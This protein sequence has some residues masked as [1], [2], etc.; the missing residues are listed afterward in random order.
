ME[1]GVVAVADGVPSGSGGERRP[2]VE[3]SAV[4][5]SVTQILE[6][7]D[8]VAGAGFLVAG[9]TVVTCAHVVRAAGQEPGGRVWLAFPHLAGAPT[10]AGRVL[11][12]GWRAPEAEDVA[13]VRLE[14]SPPGA[15]E[16]ALGSAE[17]CR[18]HRV[19]AFG[20]PAQ[21]PPSGHFGY[22]VAGDL[23]PTGG[24]AGPLLQLTGANDLTTGF[25][26][27][28]VVDEVTGLVIGMV[29]AISG[30]DSHLKG[31]GIA[32]ATPTQALR[33]I[34]PELLEQQ[35]SPYRGLEPFTAE[36]SRWFHGREAAVER[37]LAG[38]DRQQRA[39]LL[40][41]PS[42]AGKSSLVQAGVLPALAEG[43]VPGSGQWLTLVVRP[44]E[45]LLA[46]LERAGLPG[47]TTEGII[48]AVERRLAADPVCRRVI[49]VIDQ[50][51]ELLAQATSG[52][53]PAEA[54]LSAAEQLLAAIGSQ[55]AATVIMVVRDD[56]YP[57]LAALA[58]ELLEAAAPGLLNVP[59]NLSVPELHAIITRPAHTAGARIEDGLAERIITDVLAADSTGFSP[60]Q[61]AG[62]LL[63][64][65]ELTLSQ[66]WERREDGRLTHRAYQQLGEVTGSLTAW[67][68]TAMGRLTADQRRVAQRILTALVR[69]A[70]D[71]HL[72]PA[73]RQQVPLDRLRALASDQADG[74]AFDEV[75]TALTRRRIVTTR[76]ASRADAT[77]GLPVAELIH[78]ALIRDWQDLR[79][80]VAEDHQFHAWLHRTGE[81]RARFTDSG[82][83]GDLL[84]GTDLAE[85]LA[86][87]RQRG[88]PS[89]IA[90]FLTVS[91]RRQQAA[92]RRTRRVNTVLACLLAMALIA[93]GGALW[94]RQ[95]AV[96]AQQEAVASKEVAQSR[97]LA[98]Q[99]GALLEADPELASL[100]AVQAYRT[101]PTDEAAASLFK[102]AALPLR[103]TLPGHPDSVHSVELSPNGRTLAT[104]SD[105]MARLWDTETGKR[106]KTITGHTGRVLEVT[107]SLDGRTLATGSDDGT[108]QLLDATTG[109]GRKTLTVPGG[110]VW[111]V[112]F[113]PDGRLATGSKDGTVR[114]WDVATGKARKPLTGHSGGVY[115]MA[116]SPDGRTLATGSDDKTVRLW[117]VATGSPRKALTDPS[118]SVHS[119]M[120]SPE[121][122]TLI[123]SG[124]NGKVLL[125]DVATGKTRKTLTDPS[126]EVNSVA[127][128][129]DGRTLATTGTDAKI[130][131]W[132][133][134]TGATRETLT[135]PSGGVWSVAFGPDGRTLATGSD[136]GTV[137]L[138][139]IATDAPRTTLTGSTESVRSVAFAPDGRTLAA[140]TGRRAR[141]W[142]AVRGD[143]RKPAFTS[144]TGRVYSVAFSPNGRTLA[145][146]TDGVVQ[147][148]DA[149]TGTSQKSLGS[150]AGSLHSMAFSPD[151]RTLVTGDDGRRVRLWDVATGDTRRT[152]TD[153]GLGVA[154]AA[155]SRDGRTLA[156]GS[157]TVVRLWDPVTGKLRRT[158]PGH[159]G[160]VLQVVFSPD[161]HTLATVDGWTIRL[162]DATTGE[163]RGT[164]TGH[165]G[166]V[167]SVAFSPDG[168]T[169]ATTGED[170]KVRLWDVATGEI[171]D[172]F[173]DP[174]GIAWSV[175]FSPDGRTLATG[176]D[177]GAV[178][179]WDVTL[180]GPA[181]A[182]RKIC[183]LVH[184][185]FSA[186]ERSSYL[187]D[188]KPTPVCPS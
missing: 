162:W 28:P 149:A 101:R 22:G 12:E 113:A 7:D 87:S 50:F 181:E 110:G 74:R 56:F 52:E 136:N 163:R 170:V 114:L 88:L 128:S 142:D 126:R 13:V 29:T 124:E 90:A 71:T 5:A 14:S 43:R 58:P 95:N 161:G 187:P 104:G 141:L 72:V 24:H 15:R 184:R 180:P 118:K 73:T 48:A 100:L 167:D 106:I 109:Q 119:V 121:G 117:N 53:R 94:Q 160:R 156:T 85:G 42:G 178:R 145:T 134:A 45:D 77:P 60:R 4:L 159:A 122:R 47:A 102:A 35:V 34:W 2:A 107:F 175:A 99:S 25:S 185:D 93:A 168:R 70:D 115:S 123:T 108:V 11:P 137:R 17:G 27:G 20:F 154:H 80:W 127:L 81:R 44:G 174:G 140:G 46:E 79:D 61:A 179:L 57:R 38:L 182:V 9:D 148:W 146:G 155:F 105:T 10:V 111:S 51:E 37:V 82:H 67:C 188:Q 64:P 55:A 171:R 98:V 84:D 8:G 30:P 177:D 153:P 78:D 165:T 65:L 18:G 139:G 103:R 186:A 116:F 69:P 63:P 3:A 76:T 132:D 130:R 169:L 164:L 166:Y 172:T 151:G 120:F 97:Q 173:S 31:L 86:W 135:D 143:A 62:T 26:G 21:A 144:R 152:F 96:T 147:L 23:L 131:V 157:D 183:Q 66:L 33:E 92:V 41:G 19:S 89:D 68:N 16:L 176:G 54:G 83:P 138:W 158:L 125:R 91:H 75:L 39:L 40:L 49:L 36:H 112:A 6:G 129:P 133:V 32:Y 59:A 1:G 150:Q